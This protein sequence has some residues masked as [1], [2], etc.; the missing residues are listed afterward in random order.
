MRRWT[1]LAALLLAAC[2]TPE[3]RVRV[4]IPDADSLEAPVADLPLIALPY[5]RDSVLAALEAKAATPRPSTGKLDTL[6]AAFRAPFATYARLAWAATRR[7][8]A[9]AALRQRL[10]SIPRGA[11]EYREQYARFL[12]LSDS[13]AAMEP[14]L[15][16]ARKGL[17]AGRT[18]LD[19][20]A[21][22]LRNTIREWENSTYRAYDSIT[23]SL[24]KQSGRTPFADTTGADGRVRMRLGPG[25]WWIY[26]RSWDA[27]DPNSEWYWNI[28]VVGDSLTLDAK[29]A[30]RR[31]RY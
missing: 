10:D 28:P 24:A 22:P 1:P 15:G 27:L 2:S 16:R 7:R 31:A 25:R 8:D 21:T 12:A 20:R 6:L 17:D 18:A 13:L 4:A 3:V 19:Q 9:L 23:A 5:D 29:N 14:R 11:P 26:A 30:K